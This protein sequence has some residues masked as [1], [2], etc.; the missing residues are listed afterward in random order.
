MP[1]RSRPMTALLAFTGLNVVL[2]STISPREG[3]RQQREA[4]A[5]AKG[6]ESTQKFL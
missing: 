1:H 5:L 3:C 4:A 6:I 2:V